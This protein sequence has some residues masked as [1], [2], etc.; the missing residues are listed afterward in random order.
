VHSSKNKKVNPPSPAKLTS[1]NAPKHSHRRIAE[2]GGRT[3]RNG[4]RVVAEMCGKDDGN[5]I[6]VPTYFSHRARRPAAI[7][8]CTS[9][10]VNIENTKNLFKENV[11]LNIAF[12][13]TITS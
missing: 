1:R 8:R 13:I 5:R 2:G 7:Y 3:R 12:P 6:D 4:S 10:N 11:K 9:G